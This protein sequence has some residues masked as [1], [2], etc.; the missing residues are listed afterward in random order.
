M[1]SEYFT[2]LQ[3]AV[4]IEFRYDPGERRVDYYPDGSGH[5]G[6]PPSVEIKAVRFDGSAFNIVDALPA[7]VL[8]DLAAEILENYDP[9]DDR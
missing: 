5:P 1:S 6:C 9:E 4:E 8:E 2:D 7:K 3:C